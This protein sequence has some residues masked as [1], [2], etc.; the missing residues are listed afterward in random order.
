[1]SGIRL[2]HSNGGA[3]KRFP[4][5][6]NYPYNPNIRGSHGSKILSPYAKRVKKSSRSQVEETVQPRRSVSSSKSEENKTRE[7]EVS[8]TFSLSFSHHLHSHCPAKHMID[9]SS[10]TFKPE[11]RSHACTVSSFPASRHPSFH[12]CHTPFLCHTHK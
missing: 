9:S 1:M 8:P 7:R 6:H 4:F 3:F 10:T 12:L 11:K 5:P 2:P